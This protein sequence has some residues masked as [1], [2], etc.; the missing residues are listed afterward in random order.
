MTKTTKEFE[1][2]ESFFSKAKLPSTIQLEAGVF[3]PDTKKFVDNNLAA[4]GSGL[5]NEVASAG[6]YYRMNR[7]KELLQGSE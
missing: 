7:L 4:L 5:M 3:V 1:Q 2:I 6:R